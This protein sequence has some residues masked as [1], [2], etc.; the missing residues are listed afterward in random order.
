[1]ATVEVLRDGVARGLLTPDE[2]SDRMATAFA[3]RHRDELPAL[4]AD[5]PPLASPVPAAAVGWRPLAA[6]LVAQLR[7]EAAT[8]RTAGI[9]SRRALAAVVVAVVTVL[10]FVALVSLVAHGLWHGGPG[11]GFDE[12]F[13]DGRR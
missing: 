10:L 1:M 7:S 9:R 13:R 3:A 11:D 12:G 8:T 6:A 2:G 5:L 4:T